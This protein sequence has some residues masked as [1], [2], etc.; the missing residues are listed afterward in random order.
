MLKPPLLKDDCFALPPGVD[1]IPVDQVFQYLQNA[2]TPRALHDERPVQQALGLFLAQEI[3]SERSSPPHRNSAIDGYAFDGRASSSHGIIRLKL[4]EGRSAAGHAF[5]GSVPQG[6]AIRILTG[7]VVPEGT[8]TVVLQEDVE[9]DGHELVFHGPLKPG[10]NTR[11][12]GEDIKVGQSLFEA[13]HRVS[14]ADLATL[15]SVGVSDV[16]VFRPLRVGVMS[17]G[18]EICEGGEIPAEGQI[19]DANRPMLLGQ[20]RQKGYEAI[21]LGK[22]PDDPQKVSETLNRGAE[23]CDAILTTGGASAGDEDHL[24]SLLRDKGSLEMWRIA[25]K[26]GRPMALGLW[27]GVPVFGL[28]GNPVAAL[29]CTLVFV[30]PSLRLMGGGGWHTPNGYMLPAHFT[31]KKKPGRREY[32]RARVREGGVEVFPSEGS[33]RVTGL[34]WA[35]GLVEIQDHAYDIAQGDLVK[36]IP[37]EQF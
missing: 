12:A 30:L 34:S 5:V 10:K 4:L 29:V 19:F 7:A 21:D 36:F 32:L 24:A 14:P 6:T 11:E 16:S 31:K 35:E 8:D 22:A 15:T 3:I 9:T 23:L 25:V 1:W 2:L 13:G 28:P 18:D 17:T 37:Y 33:G 20:L 26:P 27:S